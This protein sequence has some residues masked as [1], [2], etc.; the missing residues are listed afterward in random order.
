MHQSLE[1]C[2][3]FFLVGL[4]LFLSEMRHDLLIT[5]VWLILGTDGEV[6]ASSGNTSMSSAVVHGKSTFKA[7]SPLWNCLYFLILLHH[8]DTCCLNLKHLNLFA[9]T[10]SYPR[11]GVNAFSVT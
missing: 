7:M 9:D 10:W 8:V 6:V 4:C 2:R 5:K 3:Q 1:I 11:V